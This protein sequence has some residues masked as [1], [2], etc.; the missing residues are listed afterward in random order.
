MAYRSKRKTIV[1]DISWL[2]FNARVLQEAADKTVP[3]RERIRFLGIFS[4]NLDEFFR[5][6][7]A[8]LRRMI[9]FGHKANMHLENNPQ[10]IIDEI[11]MTVLNQQGEFSR[12]WEEV[13]EE[14]NKKHIYLKTEKDLTPEQQEFVRNYFE[15]TVISDIIPLMIENIPVFPTLRDKSIYLAVVMWKKESALKRKYA[16]IEIPS[17]TLGRFSILPSKHGEHHIILLEDVIR[18]NLPDIFSYFG[19]DQYKSHIF[20]VTRDAEIDIDEDISTNIIQKLEKGLKNRRKGKPVRFVYDREMDP[21]LLE[22]LVRRLHLTK[23]DNL[24]PG[25]RIHNFRHFMDFPDEVFT[26]KRNRKKPFDHPLLEDKRVSDVILKQDVML[27]F[28]YHS[29]LPLIDLLREAA[30]DP[31]V[32]TIKI[33]CYRLASQSRVVNALINAVRNGKEVIVMLELRA[34]FEEEANLEWKE[35]LEEEGAKVLIEIP[36]MKVHS[37]ICMIRKRIKTG[38]YKL[39]GF[40]STGNLNEK[41]AKVYG[42]HCLLT[43]NQRIMADVNRIFNFL[44]NP[45]SG[46][47]FL[48]DCKMIL[49]SPF[50]VKKAMLKLIDEEIKQAKKKKPAAI[51]LKMN[52]LSDDEMIMRL[53]DAA[54]AGVEIKLII[55]GIFC[56]LSENKK[57][58]KPVRAIS[59]VDE[60]LEHARV[61]VFHNKG[62]EKVYISSA[63]W[64]VRNLE[65]RV[66]ATC[67]IWNE[68]IKQELTDILNIQLE[69]NVKARWL[70]NNLSNEYVKTTKKKI[71][72]QVE[73]YNYLNKKTVKNSETGSN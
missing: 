38:S 54:K 31:D 21:G 49:P 52:S 48:R 68:D 29:F 71:R 43:S 18:F 62:K 50:I 51:T 33:T 59:I 72:S 17:R 19:Y 53:Y 55:R 5:V 70:D 25:G 11:Q 64:M 69:D 34:R 27:H 46:Q 65:H 9:Q 8:A 60:Y 56:M 7:V 10:Q 32:T 4:N 47:H 42:D 3:L 1:R 30:F 66:E 37:K 58:S 16:L 26:E 15:E 2:S 20:K 6:R 41:T 14:L 24:I 28:P 23:R 13:L 45:V 22:Y 35:R 12:I 40:V 44:E 39:Y 67:P 63:D 36:N 73:I 61:W 57:Y